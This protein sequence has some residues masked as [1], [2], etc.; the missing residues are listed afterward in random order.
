[1]DDVVLSILEK[2][3]AGETL[4]N[5]V[6]LSIVKKISGLDVRSEW[7]AM[8]TGKEIIPLS[9]GFDGHF[10]VKEKEIEEADTKNRVRSW[11]WIKRE[12]CK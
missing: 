3:R 7:E 4:G 8:H 6:F 5:E 12:E 2:D 11:Q 1:M 9:G 10:A